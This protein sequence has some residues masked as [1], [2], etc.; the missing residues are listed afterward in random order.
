MLF[1]RR[2][3]LLALATLCLGLTG[4]V[5]LD[6]TWSFAR[7]GSGTYALTLRWNADLRNRLCDTLGE[8]ALVA[9][10]GRAFPLR[11]D[12]WRETLRDLPRVD[13]KRLEERVQPGGWHEIEVQLGF[14]KPED[15]LAWELLSRRTL[16]IDPPDDQHRVALHMEPFTRLPVLDPLLAA[17]DARD[18]PP[19]RAEGATAGRD[20]PPLERL[21]IGPQEETLATR[22]L[23]PHL[24]GVRLHVRIEVAGRVRS[25]GEGTARSDPSA[26]EFTW[27]LR[28]LHGTTLS[29]WR[30]GRKRGQRRIR[31]G[32]RLPNAM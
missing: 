25:G 29:R 1:M 30:P 19:P 2:R 6:E 17:L 23:E 5:E 22:M 10:Q 21:G 3:L 7:D 26:A 15:V 32:T 27:R 20:L 8:P 31:N 9:F 16:R 12:D 18:A 11:I 13:L 4:C 14:G 24:D 28:D